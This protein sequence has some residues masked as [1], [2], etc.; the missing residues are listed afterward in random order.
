ML[1][2][3]DLLSDVR[4]EVRL[5]PDAGGRS[6]LAVSFPSVR[7]DKDVSRLAQEVFALPGRITESRKRRM[8]I[9]KCHC[10]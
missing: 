8:T 4:A 9:G 6:Q 2:L 10:E 3:R 1:G 7:S 5:E